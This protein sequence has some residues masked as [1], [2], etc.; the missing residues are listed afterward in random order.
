MKKYKVEIRFAIQL[1]L[2]TTVSLLAAY[3]TSTS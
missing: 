1:L 2:L 3:L